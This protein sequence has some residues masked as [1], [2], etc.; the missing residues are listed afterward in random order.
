MV[1]RGQPPGSQIRT[2]DGREMMPMG[3]GH[4]QRIPSTVPE[5]QGGFVVLSP[6]KCA[7]LPC[8]GAELSY[9]SHYVCCMS[10]VYAAGLLCRLFYFNF[11]KI[12][13]GIV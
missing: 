13:R 10:Y 8:Y 7:Q 4:K 12:L 5:Q 2:E 9:A 3:V 11:P 1:H 6:K